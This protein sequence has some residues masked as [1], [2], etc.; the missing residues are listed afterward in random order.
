MTHVALLGDRIDGLHPTLAGVFPFSGV[1]ATASQNVF[2]NGK[3]AVRVGDISNDSCP[4]EAPAIVHSTVS[5]GSN[6]VFINGQK[7]AYGATQQMIPHAGASV[8][9]ITGGGST[10]VFIA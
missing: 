4:V 7:A 9:E 3:A 2:I 6:K 8:A 1:I 10:T 5:I